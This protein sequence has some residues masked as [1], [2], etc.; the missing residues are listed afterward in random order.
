MP[1]MVLCVFLSIQSATSAEVSKH[2]SCRV[3]GMGVVL[4]DDKTIFVKRDD[5]IVYVAKRVFRR[6]INPT[7]GERI[8]ET[9]SPGKVA[10]PPVLLLLAAGSNDTT[11]VAAATTAIVISASDDMAFE[12]ISPRKIARPTIPRV[13]HSS[14]SLQKL[15]SP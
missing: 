3:E 1:D 7:G 2:I 11:T 6:V 14:Q 4:V 13:G 15:Q 10:R 9:I 12:T 5:D 8:F